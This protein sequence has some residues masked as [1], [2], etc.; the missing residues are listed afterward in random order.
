MN[1]AF[2]VNF[3]G[4][5]GPTHNYSG[6]SYGN[7]ASMQNQASISN[8]K[9]AALQGLE[10]MQFLSSLG[11]KQAILPPHERPHL[12]TLMALGYAGSEAYVLESAF[13][14]DPEI[15]YNCSS[16][17]AMWTANAA[18]CTPS[19]DSV[20]NRAHFTAANLVSKFHR[21]LESS[22]THEI[23]KQ[24]FSDSVFF[25]HHSPLPASPDFSDE[26]AANHT[27]LCLDYAQPGIHLFVYGRHAW[28]PN[29][30]KPKNF[31]ARQTLEASQS[32]ARLHRLFPDRVVFAQQNPHA[33]DAGVF[34]ND[35]ASVGNK[36][37]FLYHEE[38]FV[39]TPKTIEDLQLKM[40]SLCKSELIPI[41]VRAAD[42]S[43]QEAVHSYLFNSQL[44]SLDSASMA[45]IAPSECEQLPAVK[46]TLENILADSRNPI[47]EVHYFNL[48]ESMRNGGGPACLR[49]RIVLTKEELQETHPGIFLTDKLYRELK[50]W[51][52][53]HYRD[54]LH[55]KNLA[56]PILWTEIKEALNELTQI[57]KLGPIYPF[58]KT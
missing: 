49:L 41:E 2:E 5:V 53:L 1:E 45:L 33:I 20:D 30:H 7:I 25:R 32:I 39:D 50:A 6:L 48:H 47:R 3:E 23:L 46:H 24:I 54:Q 56:D 34:H 35:V 9:K 55:P 11:I 15:F 21:S 52:E 28:K 37:V 31:P 44:V 57:L 27:R 36:N 12:P 40:Q 14:Q 16:A 43:L 51:I 13:S 26:G 10:K 19:I 42:V 38:A 18:T 17:S 22:F 58:Q 8:P 4:L 29:T